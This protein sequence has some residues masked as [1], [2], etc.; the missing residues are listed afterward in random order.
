MA[1]R[2]AREVEHAIERGEFMDTSLTEGVTLGDALARY[3]EEVTPGKRGG[4]QEASRIK[5]LR[6]DPI[7]RLRLDRVRTPDVIAYRNRKLAEGL[8][9]TTVRLY[10]AVISHLFNVAIRD[11][12]Y[13]HL[14]NPV[15]RG[16]MPSAAGN[17]RDRRLQPGE[18]EYLLNGCEEYGGF[19]RDAVI[20]ALETAMRRGEIA[21]LRWEHVN[22]QKRVVHLPETKNG[23]A[24]DV[25]LSSRA[26]EVLRRRSKVRSIRDSRVFGVAPNGISQAFSRVCKAVGIEDLRFHDLR[27]EATSRLF[28]KGLNPM[29]VAA[30]TGHKTLQMLKRYTHLRAEDLVEL[31]G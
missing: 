6:Q 19:I 2:W 5:Q 14:T 16:I 8:S 10:L 23:S 20:F 29:Q 3:E 9:P 7:A 31:L 25:P 13:A 1:E 15:V 24:R 22:I 4:R 30:I 26:I 12:G 27:H 18:E 28:E 21:N 11:W 17:E